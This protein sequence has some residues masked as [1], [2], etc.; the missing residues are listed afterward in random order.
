[1]VTEYK[2]L[3]RKKALV[4]TNNWLETSNGRPHLQMQ[5][6]GNKTPK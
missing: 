6:K 1:M 3:N 5:Q 4:Y 2:L